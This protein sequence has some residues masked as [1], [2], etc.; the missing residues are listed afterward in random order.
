LFLVANLLG[1]SKGMWLQLHCCVFA[2]LIASCIITSSLFLWLHFRQAGRQSCG[3]DRGKR[4]MQPCFS[5][6]TEGKGPTF[7][8]VYTE[9]IAEITST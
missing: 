6:H 2:C 9:E 3:Y 7:Y 1:Q 4:A 8:S 5:V